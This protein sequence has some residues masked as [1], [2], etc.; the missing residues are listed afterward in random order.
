MEIAEFN[1]NPG[2]TIRIR[3][4]ASDA[5]I[6]GAQS[7]ESRWITLQVVSSEELFYE[8]LT[9]QREQRARF[10]KAL[11]TAKE[12]GDSLVKLA[13]PAEASQIVRAHQAMTRQ[14]WQVAGQLDATLMEMTLNDLGTS[15][16]RDLLQS[17][18]I[19]PLRELHDHPLAEQLKRL[20]PLTQGETVDENRREAA[21]DAQTEVVKQMQ[22]ILDQ[23]SQWESFVDVVNQLRHVINS[24]NVIRDSTDEMQKKQIKDVFE[25]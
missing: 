17:S 6:L 15:A 13:K 24:Q 9:R 21:I 16:A 1:L 14:V 20:S 3:A 12:L 8:I 7:A 19:Q 4:K 22:R 10:A 18:V 11:D 25:E 5:C 23:M 2:T